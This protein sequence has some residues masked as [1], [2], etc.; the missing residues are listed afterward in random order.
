M[1]LFVCCVLQVHALIDGEE[2]KRREAELKGA[3]NATAALKAPPDTEGLFCQAPC[4]CVYVCVYVWIYIEC[5][6]ASVHPS[7]ASQCAPR[8]AVSQSH[9]CLCS[10]C[11]CVCFC[12]LVLWS[13][14][15]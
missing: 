7:V 4:V 8:L 14:K 2:R 3:A 12:V 11:V 5:V 6:C 9:C 1:L 15:R 13:Q 10:V